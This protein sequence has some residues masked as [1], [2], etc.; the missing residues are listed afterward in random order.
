VLSWCLRDRGG[1]RVRGS[2]LE[3][4]SESGR[5][6]RGK[7]CSGSPRNGAEDGTVS[8]QSI[9]PGKTKM[10]RAIRPLDWDDGVENVV[11]DEKA[12]SEAVLSVRPNASALPP[13]QMDLGTMNRGS[14]YECGAIAGFFRQAS[15]IHRPGPLR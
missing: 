4:E 9:R 10:D 13:Q 2:A 7:A 14:L 8:P 11:V 3:R 5:E 6:A 1:R 12:G 15:G